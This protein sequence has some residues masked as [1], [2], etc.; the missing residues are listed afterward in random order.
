MSPSST[1]WCCWCFSTCFSTGSIAVCVGGAMCQCTAGVCTSA[2]RLLCMT[3][4]LPHPVPLNTLSVQAVACRQPCTSSSSVCDLTIR[5][6]QA[7]R[8]P[9]VVGVITFN[10]RRI[11]CWWQPVQSCATCMHC[12]TLMPGSSVVFGIFCHPPI[13]IQH[14]AAAGVCQCTLC[15]NTASQSCTPHTL[16]RECHSA[17]ATPKS[18]C[19]NDQQILHEALKQQQQAKGMPLPGPPPKKNT[20]TCHRSV[21]APR[22]AQSN[23]AAAGAQPPPRQ[24]PR[25][26]TD[27]AAAVR[28]QRLHS[29]PLHSRQDP[30]P[31]QQSLPAAA[32]PPDHACFAAK[33]P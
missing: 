18:T 30:A 3:G 8:V 6:C 19:A 26:P 29:H 33:L 20:L 16:D 9:N 27:P 11:I 31:T 25:L 7:G 10:L 13:S 14:G 28:A 24:A 2:L 23:P 4:W 32:P 12:P 21:A 22:P 5:S 17:T 15:C 1:A